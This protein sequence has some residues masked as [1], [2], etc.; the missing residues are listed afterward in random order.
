MDNL[1]VE[2]WCKA[3]G[4]ENPIPLQTI[5]FHI[6]PACHLELEAAEEELVKTHAQEKFVDVD[7]GALQL[8]MPPEV[9][10]MSDCRLRVYLGGLD[11]RGQ[12]H[13]VGHRAR[14]NGLIYSNAVMVDQLG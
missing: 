14:D 3:P 4:A 10:P 9:G 7:V 12:F 1:T 8:E 11:S 13:I 6:S 2:G 5:R